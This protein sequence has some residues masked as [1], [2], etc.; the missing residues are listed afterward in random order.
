LI[1]ALRM[2]AALPFDPATT[3]VAQV[4]VDGRRV[5]V[6]TVH[7]REKSQAEIAE[8]CSA[9]LSIARRNRDVLIVCPQHL[10]G[11]FAHPFHGLAETVENIMLLPPLDYQSMVWLIQRCHFLITD[12][13]G[14]Q[15]EAAE[16]GK[17]TLVVRKTTERGEGAIAGT[18][19][20]V[21]TDRRTIENWAT[22]LLSEPETYERMARPIRPYGDG[23]AARTI[24]DVL[25]ERSHPT[26]VRA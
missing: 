23:H 6:A 8:I 7:R 15:E 24:V 20:L 5:V 16:I 25:F 9:L 17:P 12:S 14:L 3:P 1:D 22:R 26:A 19:S 11:S 10:N 13:G 4:A 18:A 21:G 2:V